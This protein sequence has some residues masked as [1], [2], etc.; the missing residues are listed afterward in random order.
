VDLAAV[1]LVDGG[2]RGGRGGERPP[3]DRNGNAAFI[4]NRTRGNS[5]RI[6]G[7]LFYTFGNSDFERAPIFP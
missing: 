2:G 6:T 3:R 1:G 4:G 7:S 5:N